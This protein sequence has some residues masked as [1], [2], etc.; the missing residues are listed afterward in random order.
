LQ[1]ILYINHTHTTQSG[2]VVV[3]PP[4]PLTKTK[5]ALFVD[6]P[7]LHSNSNS[8]S[9]VTIVLPTRR[10]WSGPT[11]RHNVLAM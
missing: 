3:E 11:K 5:A 8:N 9:S 10:V 2:D 6:M 1:T 4:Q 7:F